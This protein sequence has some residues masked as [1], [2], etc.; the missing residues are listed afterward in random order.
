MNEDFSN[1][2]DNE[3][4][5]YVYNEELDENRKSDTFD[6]LQ[7]LTTRLMWIHSKK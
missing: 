3:G 5:V 1:F 4:R 6:V 7:K 2:T